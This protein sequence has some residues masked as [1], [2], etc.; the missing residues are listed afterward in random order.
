VRQRYADFGPTLAAEHLAK[1]GWS[2]SRETLRK[3]MTR[4]PVV[5]P[6]LPA[7]EGH[8]CVAR[9]ASLFW[10]DGDAG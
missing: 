7:R 9:T 2:V 8:P 5:A 3:W 1:E 6:P 10:R 4:G